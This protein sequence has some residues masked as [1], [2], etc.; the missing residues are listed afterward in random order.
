MTSRSV[1]IAVVVVVVAA[2]IAV[3]LLT[4]PLRQ[5]AGPT[6]S[7][8]FR[9]A[10][11]LPGSVTD[12]GW[13]AK[14]FIDAQKAAKDLDFELEVV[15]GVGQAG[16][17][18][19]STIRSFAEKGFNI[20]VTWTI[21]H[22]DAVLRIA[23]DFPNTFFVGVAFF[24]FNDLPNVVSAVD[25]IYQAAYLSGMVAGA[26]TK[27]NTIGFM[28]G[29]QF[30][31]QNAVANA[32]LEG[33]KRVNPNVKLIWAYNGVWDDV[34][35]GRETALA[36]IARGADVIQ[37]RGDGIT[38]G[39]I[40]ACSLRGVFCVGDVADQNA[41][42]PQAVITSNVYDHTLL[43][44]EIVERYKAGTLAPKDPTNFDQHIIWRYTLANGGAYIAPF[45]EQ[46]S[47]V[48]QHVKDLI[49][50]VIEDAKTG[51]FDVPFNGEPPAGEQA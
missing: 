39:G 42:S 34:N 1:I 32:F 20:I 2:V 44:K 36:L 12:S 50:Q 33:A 14:M 49:R 23:P 17:A 28:G 9:I 22:Q 24:K 48:P 35:K 10:L 40:Q 19:D 7:G 3:S 8:K 25:S 46:D 37:L 5:Q 26:V 38:L 15:E 47:L 13:N 45:Y 51:R 6:P 4:I 29:Q 30:P 27:T 31:T 41:L 18:V 16:P 21:G 11:I 43:F